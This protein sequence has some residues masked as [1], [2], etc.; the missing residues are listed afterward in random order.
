MIA[1][2]QIL[3]PDLKPFDY[4]IWGVLDNKTNATSH[5]NIGSVKTAFEEEWNKMFEE[6]MLKTFKSFRKR[7]HRIILEMVAIL[8]KFTVL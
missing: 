3:S 6:F 5:P 8:S 7:V 1:I 4:A 2:K